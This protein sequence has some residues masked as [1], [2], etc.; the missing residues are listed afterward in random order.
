MASSVPFQSR[1]RC[2]WRLAL[3]AS[4]DGASAHSHKKSFQSGMLRGKNNLQYN[5][6]C[7]GKCLNLNLCMALVLESAGVRIPDVDTATY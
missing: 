6:I 3:R 1:L 4:T 7:A 2:D 5:C